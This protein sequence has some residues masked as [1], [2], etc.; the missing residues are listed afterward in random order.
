MRCDK[1]GQNIYEGPDKPDVDKMT[2]KILTDIVAQLDL[3]ALA[4][5]GFTLSTYEGRC[6]TL[7]FKG[8]PK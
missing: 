6:F 2:Q 5:D 3:G 8:H 1:C 7:E 4:I